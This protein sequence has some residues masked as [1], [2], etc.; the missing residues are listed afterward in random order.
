M[1]NLNLLLL[2]MDYEL[3]DSMFLVKQLKMEKSNFKI[4]DNVDFIINLYKHIHMCQLLVVLLLHYITP[5]S[6]FWSCYVVTC[7]TMVIF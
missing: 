5:S 6:D 4:H 2:V 3:S 7:I 1:I